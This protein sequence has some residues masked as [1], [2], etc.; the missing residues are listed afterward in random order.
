MPTGLGGVG[1]HALGDYAKSGRV[2]VLGSQ[3][4]PPPFAKIERP[5]DFYRDECDSAVS[6]CRFGDGQAVGLISGAR[7]KEPCGIEKRREAEG[8]DGIREPGFTHPQHRAPRRRSGN[9]GKD[10][11]PWP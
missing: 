9:G 2:S 6:Q 8:A 1:S 11:S 7:N 4:Q 10:Q 5:G 3:L